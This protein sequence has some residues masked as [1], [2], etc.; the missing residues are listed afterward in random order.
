M[1]FNGRCYGLPKD[2]QLSW[3][4][5]ELHC[6][7]WLPGAHLASVHSP[8]ERSFIVDNFPK[9]I[10]LGGSD[11]RQEGS[12]EWTDGTP[13]DYS[14]WYQGEPNNYGRNQDCLEERWGDKWDDNNCEKDQLFVCKK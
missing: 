10:W 5:A 4:A 7:N 14:A 9:H 2:K 12:W 8:E 13:F 6:Q 3:E 1:K 11:V